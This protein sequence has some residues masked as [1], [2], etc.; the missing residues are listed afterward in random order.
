MDLGEDVLFLQCNWHP[1]IPE[2]IGVTTSAG[3]A[4][5]LRLD[6]EYRITKEAVDLPIQNSLEA[7]CIA[8]SPPGS[9]ST[10]KDSQFSVYCG[11]DDSMLRYQSCDWNC[12]DQESFCSTP[13]PPITIKGQHMAGVTAILPLPLKTTNG[14]RIV[15]TGSYDDHL[16]VFSIQDL[17][18]SYGLK[19]VELILEE[20]LG[21]GVWRLDHVSTS[22]QGKCTRITILVSCM[23]AGARLVQLVGENGADWTCIILARFEEHKSMNYGSALVPAKDLTGTLQIVSTSFYDQL[24]CLW[25]YR[26]SN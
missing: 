5:L 6:E 2:V 17:H 14:G 23:H 18:D 21:G 3:A 9:S 8:F 10:E 7:W 19:R 13:Y 4:R 24:L 11:G 12:N 1:V 16:R 26:P 22:S 15:V 20:N 25:E